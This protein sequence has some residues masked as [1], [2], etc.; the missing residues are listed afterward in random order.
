MKTPQTASEGRAGLRRS[1]TE[2]SADSASA[3]RAAADAG[4]VQATFAATL[5]D[6]WARFGVTDAVISPGS[7]S[8][9]LALALAADGRLRLHIRLDERSA[10]FF[11]LGIARR[12]GRVTLVV[13]T[14]GTAAAELHPAVAEADLGGVALLVCTAD[15]PPELQQ[16]AAPQTMRQPG[17]YGS[18]VRW[19]AEAGVPEPD[20]GVFWRSLAAR[21][22]AEAAYGP[23]GPG[24]VHL[25]LAFRDPLVAEPGPLPPARAHGPWHR[26]VRGVRAPSPE[27]VSDL[28]GRAGQ[29]GVIVAGSG[30]GD[31]EAIRALAD[32][33][34]WPV[35]A[36]PRSGARTPHST[37]VAAADAI[38]R[39]PAA[40]D[41]LRPSAVL[42]LGERWA[43]RVMAE[44]LAHP[45]IEHLTVDP[46]W[47]WRD[48]Q[49]R[50]D[51]VLCADPTALC[52]AA[53]EAVPHPV[54][55][56]WRDAW[57]DA[58]AAAQQA[59]DAVLNSY[60]DW[61]EPRVARQL[62]SAL[63]PHTALV[64][65]S[66]MPI[67]HLEWFTAPRHRPPTVLSN[68]GVNGIDGVVSTALGAAAA[69]TDPVVALIGDLT[70]LHDA[71]ALLGA[72]DAG[73]SCTFVVVD[74]NGGGIF[75]FLPPARRLP[76]A[77]FEALFGTPQSADI[78]AIAAAY[79]VTVRSAGDHRQ[80]DAVLAELVEKQGVSVI[81][82]RTDREA[83]V[84]VHERVHAAVA[85]AVDAVLE[86]E[87]LG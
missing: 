18:A 25:N 49:R 24:P 84:T 3:S 52:R 71:G 50:A 43:S 47:R 36:D 13:T 27:A 75:S 35:L 69:T 31:P 2:Q 17:L 81:H 76:P 30:A 70:F 61:T 26:V 42:H 48:P 8:T 55:S 14:S 10:G 41:R 85:E 64:V 83:N 86:G 87:R 46:D 57:A 68:R 28:A 38:L 80:L 33:L 79:G 37:T 77:T 29:R 58:E 9:P 19:A 51:T 22:V 1:A 54:P 5:V 73:L 11:A 59:L 12:T 16:V 67:R 39:A 45:A 34:G 56:G 72:A 65:G 63:P 82:V 66:S 23:V 20:Q 21:A 60:S 15:R 53:A 32:A 4:R 74:N 6:E 40:R 44:W 62:W 78:P 7:R